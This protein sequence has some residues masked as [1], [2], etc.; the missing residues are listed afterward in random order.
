MIKVVFTGSAYNSDTE[1]EF[2]GF[3]D[4]KWS[5]WTLHELESDV[6]T[7]TFDTE[8][9]ALEFIESEI[10]SADSFDGEDFYAADAKLNNETGETFTY[11][12]R[13]EVI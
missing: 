9:E 12:A 6:R 5:M 2:H 11:H 7:W 4:P 1:E 10:G 8:A 3:L 13:L